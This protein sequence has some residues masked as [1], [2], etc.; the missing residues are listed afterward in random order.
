MF[1]SN[2]HTGSG[3]VFSGSG[4]S[5]KKRWGIEAGFAEIRN[6]MQDTDMKRKWETGFFT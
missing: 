5:L 4:I 6:G 1:V 3:R 2:N